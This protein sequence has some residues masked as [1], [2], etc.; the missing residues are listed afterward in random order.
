[1]VSLLGV[2][3]NS[4][5]PSL[6]LAMRSMSPREFLVTSTWES[7]ELFGMTAPVLVVM[8]W[9]CPEARSSVWEEPSPWTILTKAGELSVQGVMS[10][11]RNC[12]RAMP[13]RVIPS[14]L[15]VAFPGMPLKKREPPAD[16]LTWTD[17]VEAS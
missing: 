5:T 3:A 7:N 13:R 8:E 1:M 12:P 17:L 14:R 9:S 11:L 16:W 2:R 15:A 4:S 6:E 10:A